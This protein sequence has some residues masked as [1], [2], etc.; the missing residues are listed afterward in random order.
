MLRVMVG[1]LGFVRITGQDHKTPTAE[2]ATACGGL[3]IDQLVLRGA[4]ARTLRMTS[5]EFFGRHA[6]NRK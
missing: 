4:D 1:V 3:V 5:D 2:R 6:G